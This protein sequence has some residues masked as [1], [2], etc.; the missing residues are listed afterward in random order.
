MRSD[1]CPTCRNGLWHV[2]HV[3]YTDADLAERRARADTYIQPELPLEF[4]A[5]EAS[6]V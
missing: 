4:P 5:E 1:D 2:G 3:C 6:D